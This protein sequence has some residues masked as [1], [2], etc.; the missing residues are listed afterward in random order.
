MLTID[1]GIGHDDDLVVTQFGDI[2]I[3]A[4]TTA[5]SLDHHTDLGIVEDLVDSGFFNIQDLASQRQDG[6]EVGITSLLRRTA[7]GITLNDVDL[8]DR[9]IAGSTVL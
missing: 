6:L 1:I 7:G 2:D 8:T 5:K 9:G 3:I 4:E